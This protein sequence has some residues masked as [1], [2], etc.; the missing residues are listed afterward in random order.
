[1]TL[2]PNRTKNSLDSRVFKLDGYKHLIP[3][4]WIYAATKKAIALAPLSKPLLDLI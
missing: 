2:T 1:M 4:S 3:R